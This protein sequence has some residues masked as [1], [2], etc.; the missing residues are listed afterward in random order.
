MNFLKSPLNYTG[1][2]HKLLKQITPLFPD[3]IDTFVDLFAGG[4]NVAVNVDA[5]RIIA[6][7]INTDIINLYEFFKASDANKLVE[8]I[9][10]IIDSYGLSN[11]SKYGYDKY[12]TNSSKGVGAYNKKAYEK[13]RNDYNK[14]KTPLMFYTTLVFAFNNQIRFNSKGEFNTP[15]NKRDFNKNMRKNLELFID[16]LNNL[17]ISFSSKDFKDIS[18][19]KDSFVYID[20]P[21]LATLAAYNENG[22]WGEAKEQELLDYMDALDAKGV[23]FALSNVFEN[24]GKTNELLLKWSKKYKVNHLTYTYHNCNYQAKNKEADSTKEILITNY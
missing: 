16:R 6:N 11:T 23:K 19:S 24:K 9:D 3:K 12:K 1:G 18:V 4:C 5:K 21:Y 14:N 2:K 15:V 17:N 20:P 8:Q 13:L 10:A 7:D 22:G